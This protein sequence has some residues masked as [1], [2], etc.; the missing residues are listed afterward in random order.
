MKGLIIIT[1]T[2]YSCLP[3]TIFLFITFVFPYESVDDFS[4][5]LFQDMLSQQDQLDL[6]A[7]YIKQLRDRIEKLKEMREEATKSTKTSNS[8]ITDTTNIG[9]RLPLV[10]LREVG[11]T[12]EVVLIT[13]LQKNFMLFEVISILEE[14]GAEVVNASFSTLGDKLFHSIHAQVSDTVNVD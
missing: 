2:C 8:N 10:E 13:G 1:I 12:I 7:A 3:P 5:Q 4:F 9:L 6:A 11:P 14:E